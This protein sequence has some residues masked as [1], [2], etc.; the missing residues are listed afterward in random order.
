MSLIHKII[1]ILIVGLLPIV[2]LII[3]L[4]VGRKA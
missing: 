1:W 2:G 3:Y 4:L